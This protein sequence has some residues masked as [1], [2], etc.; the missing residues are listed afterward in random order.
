VVAVL[1]PKWRL[2]Y[3]AHLIEG[4]TGRAVFVGRG[5]VLGQ[6]GTSGNAVGKAPHLHYAVVSLVPLPW[7]Y[8]TATQ[9]WK[10]V[11]YLD[12]GELLATPTD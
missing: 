9:G 7:R 4:S 5:H 1:G 12:P 2:H 3:Y 6:V 11:F 10:R 8:S